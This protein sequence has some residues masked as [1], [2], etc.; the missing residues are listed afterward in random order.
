M[1]FFA[2]KKF[3]PKTRREEKQL[4]T[5]RTL[6]CLVFPPGALPGT[7]TQKSCVISCGAQMRDWSLF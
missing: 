1:F 2:I 6:L 5:Q 4:E 7:H 3:S